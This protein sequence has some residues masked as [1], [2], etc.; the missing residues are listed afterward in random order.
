MSLCPQFLTL[1]LK[2]LLNNVFCRNLSRAKYILEKIIQE[3]TTLLAVSAEEKKIAIDWNIP[4]D[5]LLYT[6]Y[7]MLSFIIRNLLINAI[8]YTPAHGKITITANDVSSTNPDHPLVR[9]CVTDT[10]IGIPKAELPKL[11][12]AREHYTR[13]GTQNEKGVGLGLM[14]CKEFV[15]KSGGTI[16][17]SSK[18][19]EGT[20]FCFEVPGKG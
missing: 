11:F 18:L 17:V 16:T 2:T 8:K 12:N 3:T 19:N 13:K 7:N 6:D 9:I 1:I 10:G 5:T 4:K 20:T 14:L 15:E